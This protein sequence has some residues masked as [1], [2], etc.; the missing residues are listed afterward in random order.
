MDIRFIAWA[1]YQLRDLGEVQQ[2]VQLCGPTMTAEEIND[3]PSIQNIRTLYYPS[4]IPYQ[5]DCD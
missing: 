4:A 3:A 2:I 1:G 5:R